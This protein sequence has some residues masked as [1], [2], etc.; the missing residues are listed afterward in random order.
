MKTIYIKLFY[1]LLLLPFI[2]LAQSTLDGTVMDQKTK[3]PIPGVN[4]LVQGSSG[5]TQTDFDGKFKLANVKKGD[6]VV[7]SY[8]G[9]KNTTISYNDQ[10]SVSIS[11]EEDSNELKE[12][13]VQVGYG[14]VKKKD[15]TGSVA[16]I[17]SKDFN[18]GT[19]VGV[20]QMVQGKIAG[21]Q[22]TTQGGSPGE[23]G[24]FRIRG[25]SS[26]NANN[27]PLYV[28]DGVPVDKEGIKGGKNPLATINQNN[29]E[30]VTVLKD[31]SAAAI[32]GSRASN[33]VII[34]TTKKGKAG[35]M[36]MNYNGS[37]SVSTIAKQTKVLSADEF[38]SYVNTYGSSAQKA[39]LGTQSTD[40]QK[41]IF[42]TALGTEHNLA[43][44]GGKEYLTYRASLGVSNLNGLLKQDNFLRNTIGANLIG[45]FFDN[46]LKIEVNNNT[47]SMKNNYSNKD[48]IGGAI[49]YDPSQAIYNNDGTYFQWGSTLAG[50]NPLALLNQKKNFGTAFNSVGNIQTEY[51]LHFLPELKFVANLGYEYRE[52]RGYGST[53]QD[54]SFASEKG[55]S[56]VNTESK[57]NRLMDLY[58]NYKKD[59]SFIKG[60][61]ELTSGY[62]Y[63]N[64][65]REYLDSNTDGN[66]GISTVGVSTPEIVNLQSYFGRIGFNIY[67]KY[68]LTATLRRDG[69]SRFAPEYKWGNFPSLAFAWKM[70]DESFI[71]NSKTIS[72]LKMRLG[73]GITGQQDVTVYP[74]IAL[75][76]TSNSTAQ[77]QIGNTFYNTIRPQPYNSSLKWE[78]TE[79]LNAGLDFGLFDNRFTGSVDIYEKRTKDLL[80]FVPNPAFF[81]FSNY[82]NYNVGNLKN[83]GIELSTDFK[84]I[85]SSDLNWNIGGNITFQ[86][87]NVTNLIPGAPSVG[88]PN[89]ESINGGIDNKIQINQV[90][91]T[92]NSF[93]VYEQIYDANGK[94]IDGAF[95]DRNGDGSISNADLYIYKKPTPDVFYGL[96][97]NLSYK[98]I[99][100]SMTWRG[101]LG[102]YV[103]N[104]VDSNLG[105]Q[106]QLLIRET[107]LSNAVSEVLNTNLTYK[108]SERYLSDYYIQDASFIKLDNVSIG[109]NFD[110]FL[111]TKTTSRLSLGGQNLLIITK[112]KGIDPEVEK[113]IDKS[114]Y[115][116][117]RIITLGL[118]VNF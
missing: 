10:K 47:S 13:V 12:V 15:A 39:I 23:G 20:D 45:K 14:S 71:K 107:D 9:Y 36:Q 102:N 69:T 66:S 6:K 70:S 41:E 2:S 54:Y 1:L 8:I 98:K 61:V 96:Y 72:N 80:A 85:R 11:L 95:V 51:K 59:L 78:E 91:Y 100:F 32:Y 101:S 115:P 81:G 52:G 99:D 89:S 40:W 58:V 4:V 118:N 49:S 87:S 77:Y 63:Q 18:K 5:G 82:D 17:T 93:F 31:A 38:K 75:Y 53:S 108:G 56:Y 97:T 48:A 68:L 94:P 67:D 26:L 105:W 76:L 114:I 90:G 3:Q 74:S 109:Y 27:D 60:S 64:F 116:R 24:I 73:W 57:K 42:R 112:Y 34:I 29:I 92:P 50:K 106:N 19:V 113:G 86:K 21:L 111:G 33:G 30:S 79:T 22:V 65:R 46:H 44:S 117:P 25:G 104:N 55:D 110:K 103:Y 35:E 83:Q 28:I 43:V 37:L 16:V 7:F 84:V 88:L 62:S